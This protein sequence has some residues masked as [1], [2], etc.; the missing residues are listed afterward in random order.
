MSEPEHDCYTD[1]RC[2]K[3]CET[4]AGCRCGDSDEHLDPLRLA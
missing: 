3:D 1:P 4:H 2:C